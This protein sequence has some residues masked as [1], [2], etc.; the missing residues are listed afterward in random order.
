MS[1]TF[2]IIVRALIQD[3]VERY[4]LLNKKLDQ[5]GDAID[6]EGLFCF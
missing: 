1:V 4:A 6:K 2:S 5:M 3:C